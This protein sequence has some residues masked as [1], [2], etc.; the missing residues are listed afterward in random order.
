[1]KAYQTTILL[2]LVFLVGCSPKQISDR[3]AKGTTPTSPCEISNPGN[4]DVDWQFSEEVNSID[5][6]E[7]SIAALNWVD[8]TG[9][10][11]RCGGADLTRDL[12][13]RSG[14]LEAY[15]VTDEMVGAPTVR[16]R[17]DD[18]QPVR[19]SWSR[20]EDYKAVFAPDARQFVRDL[21]KSKE[22]F[23]EY[24]PYEKIPKTLHFPTAGLAEAVDAPDMDHFLRHLSRDSVI[25]VCG[26]GIQDSESVRAHINYPPTSNGKIGLKFEFSTYGDDTGQLLAIEPLGA[27]ESQKYRLTWYGGTVGGVEQQMSAFRILA[28]SPGLLNA[29]RNNGQGRSGTSKSN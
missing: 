24:S 16:V 2:G 23:I 26:E 29:W 18:H 12:L 20:S 5:G 8:G 25:K 14:K 1:M 21:M 3:S 28:S 13:C 7:T 17:F 10:L 6:K 4:A 15:V 9:V 19:Q 11:L 22:L 27:E